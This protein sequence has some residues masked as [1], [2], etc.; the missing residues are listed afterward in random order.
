[1]HL[2]ID[3]R[4]ITAVLLILLGSCKVC[5]HSGDTAAERTPMIVNGKLFAAF[6]Q[7]RSAEYKALCLQ[8]YTTAT[9]QLSK[10]K[11]SGSKPLAIVTD[12]DETVLDNSPYAVRQ[13]LLGKDYEVASWYEW[14]AL[15]AA[16]TVP[17]AAAFLKY[18]SSLGVEVFY[19]TN[20]DE[21]ERAATLN[22]LRKF[23]LPNTDDL[24]FLPK[25]NTSSKE[26]RRQTIQQTHEIVMLVGD[27]L[28]DLSNIF[29][30]KSESERNEKALS[31]TKE[32]GSKYIVIPNPVYG[33]WESS[34][35]YYNY[36]LTGAQKDS[37][38]KAVLKGF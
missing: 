20:R 31:L 4:K 29:D 38:I 13:A 28:A 8:A 18:A 5:R 16:D 32:L 2:T 35:Y 25:A 6:F 37:V 24:H 7:Q 12:I 17:G 1:M 27:N 21:K 26:P 9:M 34:L 3:M 11:A 30:K 10:I 19:V 23:N 15:A 14:T 22:N 33:D 36:Q